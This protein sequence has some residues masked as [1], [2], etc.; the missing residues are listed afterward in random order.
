MTSYVVDTD[1]GPRIHAFVVG[2]GSYPYGGKAAGRGTRWSGVLR[3]ITDLTCATLS[4]QH[5][6]RCLLEADWADSAVKLGTVEI[7]VSPPAAVPWLAAYGPDTPERASFSNVSAAGHRW[8]RQC[9][10]EDVALFYFCGHGWGGVQ[11]YLLP[12]DFGEDPEHWDD[13]LIN[14][15]STH[16]D[17]I[18]CSA[19]TQ[20]FFLDTCSVDPARTTAVSAK[21]MVPHPYEE[22][23]DRSS[24]KR[25]HNPV[26]SS[27]APG[28][29]TEVDEGKVTPLA[30][31]LVRTL[32]G[33][34]AVQD[35]NQWL[36]TTKQLPNAI[37]DVM[38]WYG[39][40][41]AA[42][43]FYPTPGDLPGKRTGLR[44]LTQPPMVPFK[45]G[46][47]P[48][49]A[50]GSAEWKLC[51]LQNGAP[52]TRRHEPAEWC[53][54]APAS[55]YRLEVTFPDNS[56]VPV[57]EPARVIHPPT[58]TYDVPVRAITSRGEG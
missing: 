5:V 4:A 22:E 39:H 27:S 37:E 7:L 9:G 34:G 21:S 41:D 23:E 15:N 6:A 50:L 44:R 16:A 54:Q 53:D 47:R 8:F 57:T 46:C 56:H 2:V 35:G 51:C 58:L 3:G 17:M 49:S 36:I 25:I 42:D 20:C 19:A 1:T 29:T 14:F 26:F 43:T 10:A 40:T 52:F 28:L 33:L 55:S 31:A 12:D 45:L 18:D 32:D 13:H 24:H 48:R 38:R 11:K 30:D